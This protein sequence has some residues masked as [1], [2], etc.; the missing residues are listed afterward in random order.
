M[1]R[2][3]A[4]IERW[5]GRWR[6]NGEATNFTAGHEPAWKEQTQTIAVG[7]SGLL[8]HNDQLFED[9]SRR[10]WTFDGAFDGQPR[11]VR[12]EDGSEMMVINFSLLSEHRGAD[13][14]YAL[15]GT[16]AGAEYF[17]IT[18]ETVKV[19]GSV[20]AGGAQTTYLEVWDR[21]S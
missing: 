17:D 12:W 19:Y 8:I 14:Y 7:D 6:W 2:E 21:I 18:D 4:R 1:S 20:N 15:D 10:R 16:F 5:L 11:T 3:F 9:G 13:A